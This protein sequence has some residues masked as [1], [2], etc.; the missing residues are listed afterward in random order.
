MHLVAANPP[1]YLGLHYYGTNGN[2]AMNYL[3]SMHAK[4]P[5][6]PVIVSEIASISRN[7]A[8]V[9]GFTAQLCN[10]MD[11]TDWVFEYGWFGCMEKLADNFVS[12]AAQLMNPDGSF[13][14]LMFKLM[15]D[16][17]IKA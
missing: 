6:Q 12:P 8:D 14:D 15:Y 11:E 3:K 5:H 13:K 4:F 10:W 7:Y 16:Q 17:P 2:D 1:D 9:L